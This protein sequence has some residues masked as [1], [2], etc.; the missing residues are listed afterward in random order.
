[1]AKLRRIVSSVQHYLLMVVRRWNVV[2][3]VIA[4]AI[5]LSSIWLSVQLNSASNQVESHNHPTAAYLVDLKPFV[6][7]WS[8]HYGSLVIEKNGHAT[9]IARTYQWCGDPGVKPPCDTIKGDIIE[10]GIHMKMSF[11]RVVNKIAYGTVTETT[12]GHVGKTV[13]IKL[14]AN[15][16]IMF[17][18][19]NT[20]STS[21]PHI[22]CGPG[23]PPGQCGA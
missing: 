5:V 21:Q 4:I 18:E 9:Y 12:V 13:S 19:S 14:A 11:T 23:A 10:N 7:T 15:D 22:L 8:A 16:T 17:F 6:G 3:A 2:P 1:M 20:S